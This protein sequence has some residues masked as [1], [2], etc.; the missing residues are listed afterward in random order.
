M[1]NKEIK[2]DKTVVYKEVKDER[3]IIF[4]SNMYTVDEF[5]NKY[6]HALASYLLTRQLGDKSKKSHIVD[7]AVE[8]ASFAESLYIGMDTFK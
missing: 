4:E 2:K 6:S 8:N 7:L 5:V 1:K 3:T